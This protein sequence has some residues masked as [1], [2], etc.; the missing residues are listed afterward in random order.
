MEREKGGGNWIEGKEVG[1]E[2]SEMKE[3][4]ERWRRGEGRSGR[5]GLLQA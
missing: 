4:K 5:G 1:G 2:V 3:M